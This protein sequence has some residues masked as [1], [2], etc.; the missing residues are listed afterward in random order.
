[1]IKENNMIP[2]YRY[3]NGRMTQGDLSEAIGVSRVT[4]ARWERSIE[5]MTIKN[6]MKLCEL[7]NV[8]PNE[9]IGYEEEQQ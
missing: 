9:I 6:L 5:H 7:F 2:Y 1:M 4:I 8:S 3:K